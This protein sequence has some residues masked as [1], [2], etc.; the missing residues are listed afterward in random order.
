VGVGRL[1]GVRCPREDVGE[2]VDLVDSQDSFD[3][4]V[5]V[6]VGTDAM[7]GDEVI[8]VVGGHLG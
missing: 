2:S 7:L 5:D 3:R 8:E 6:G 4:G 1:T